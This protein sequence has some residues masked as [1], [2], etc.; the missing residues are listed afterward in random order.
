M[1]VEDQVTREKYEEMLVPVC[2]WEDQ[3][4]GQKEGRLPAVETLSCEPWSADP[5]TSAGGSFDAA[6]AELVERKAGKQFHLE[7]QK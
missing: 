3:S 4:V 7:T 6:V 1:N 2:S 5:D